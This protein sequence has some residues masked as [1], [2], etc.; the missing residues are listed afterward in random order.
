MEAPTYTGK[1]GQSYEVI[2]GDGDS[3]IIKPSPNG[4]N[5]LLC[6]DLWANKD[7]IFLVRFF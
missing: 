3:L 5:Q 4:N 1:D 6:A 2:L 7:Q